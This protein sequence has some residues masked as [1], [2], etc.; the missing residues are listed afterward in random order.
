[1]ELMILGL[2]LWSAVH[3]IP[4]TAQGLKE[5]TIHL[6]GD[7][8][9]K[10]VFSLLLIFSL[11]LI[12]YGW[13]Q[14]IP[15]SIY[16]PLYSIQFIAYGLLLTAF[17]LIALANFPTRVKQFIRHPQ[18]SGVIL[19]S[20]AHLMLNGDSRSVLLFTWMG[21]WAVMEIVLINRREEIWVKPPIPPL[22]KELIGI[23]VGLVLF[24][25]MI[26][27]HPYLSGVS[28]KVL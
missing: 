28:I 6:L 22:A 3:F 14:T 11:V 27:A 26:F 2:I 25:V 20:L 9:Y 8:G 4:S 21:L 24:I 5:K 23:A 7:N 18:L 19:W 12:S 13:R 10:G 1:M 17:I 15:S 16:P